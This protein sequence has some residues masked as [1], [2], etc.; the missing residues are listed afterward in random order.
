MVGREG[1]AVLKKAFD[2]ISEILDLN[3][4]C[5]ILSAVISFCVLTVCSKNSPVYAFND[6]VDGNAFFTVGKGIAN[7]LVPYKDLFEQKGP[8]LY[9]IYAIGYLICHDSFFGVYILEIISGA[10]FTFFLYKLIREYAGTFYSYIGA[11]LTIS[12]MF[13]STQFVQGGSAEEFCLPFMAYSF[14]SI[15]HHINHEAFSRSYFFFNGLAAGLISLIKFNLLGFWFIWMVCNFF[16]VLYKKNFKQGLFACL[17]FLAGM[18]LPILISVIVFALAGGLKDYINT[19]IFFNTRAYTTTTPFAE[20]VTDMF[21]SVDMQAKYSSCIY[22]VTIIGLIGLFT[23]IYQ[24]AVLPI[25]VI[26][27]YIFLMVGIY[28]GGNPFIYY[29]LMLSP[30]VVFGFIAIACSFEKFL[31]KDSYVRVLILTLVSMVLFYHNTMSTNHLQAKNINKMDFVQYQFAEIIDSDKDTSLLNYGF[32]DG[33]F[34]TAANVVPT[35]KYFM[36]QN[37]D[38]TKYPIIMESQNQYLKDKTTNYVVVREYFAN[39]GY[40]TDIPYLNENY[41]LISEK[42]TTYESMDVTYFLYK[43]K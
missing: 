14:Y 12:L 8:L 28:F 21:S 2:K 38:S 17:Y 27:S 40:H 33:G 29:Y 34:Y 4:I 23:R 32:L 43:R 31:F 37:V 42:K 26:L 24:K 25:F 35:V 16:Y 9:L 3:Y 39:V 15:A 19:Y 30:Y 36:L 5:L 22:V 41:Q 11:A 18:F 10:F 20:R 1:T 13:S 7:G 6:W